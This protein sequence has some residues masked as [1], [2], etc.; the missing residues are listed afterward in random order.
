MARRDVNDKHLQLRT[1]T[2]RALRKSACLFPLFSPRL[3]LRKWFPLSAMHDLQP[4]ANEYLL[5]FS[6]RLIIFLVFRDV[7]G[8]VVDVT[9]D[10]KH[11]SLLPFLKAEMPHPRPSFSSVLARMLAIS[12]LKQ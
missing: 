6:T 7:S 4:S 11:I 10:V 3:K 9:R 8:V 1:T 12:L 5:R 2:I